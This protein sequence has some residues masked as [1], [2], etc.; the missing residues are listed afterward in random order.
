M[1]MVR[2]Q[3]LQERQHLCKGMT[4]HWSSPT[5]CTTAQLEAQAIHF[6]ATTTSDQG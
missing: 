6:P 5:W 1:M 2:A 4:L 3:G